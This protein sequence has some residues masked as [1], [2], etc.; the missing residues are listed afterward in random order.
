MLYIYFDILLVKIIDE[1]A[2]NHVMPLYYIDASNSADALNTIDN[3]ASIF[4]SYL[5]N[6]LII[7]N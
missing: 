4:N 3:T 1:H 6:D 7:C 5:Y 2:E